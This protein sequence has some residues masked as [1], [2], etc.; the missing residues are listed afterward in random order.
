[1]IINTNRVFRIS[2]SLLLL[3]LI[4]GVIFS[5]MAV[6]NSQ[7][8]D[9][10]SSP[11]KSRYSADSVLYYYPYFSV[12]YKYNNDVI[13]YDICPPA[14]TPIEEL[15]GFMCDFDGGGYSM[16]YRKVKIAV[17]GDKIYLNLLSR[18]CYD[19]A[20]NRIEDI[21][22]WIQGEI[23]G[24]RIRF[25]KQT[26]LKN[27]YI[28][29]YSDDQHGYYKDPEAV[30][31]TITCCGVTYGRRLLVRY[32]FPDLANHVSDSAFWYNTCREIFY[33]AEPVYCDYYPESKLIKDLSAGLLISP[34][35][36]KKIF[37]TPTEREEASIY[38]FMLGR[39]SKKEPSSLPVPEVILHMEEHLSRDLLSIYGRPGCSVRMNIVTDDGYLLD[40]NKM[41]ITYYLKNSE[42]KTVKF[43]DENE[44]SP[45]WSYNPPLNFNPF[46]DSRIQNVASYEFTDPY[47]DDYLKWYIEDYISTL[48]VMCYYEKEDGTR[49]ETPRVKAT[50]VDGSGIEAVKDVS[51]PPTEPSSDGRIYDLTGRIMNPDNLAPGIYI[52]GGKKIIIST[53]R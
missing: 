39:I 25:D 10:I 18:E 36:N 9:C 52:K 1:M 46:E 30:V 49:I 21:P 11:S 6:T 50:I 32:E 2:Y 14:D 5:S 27:S 44:S 26:L 37:S 43:Y 45:Y 29:T 8:Q 13:D 19:E 15:E 42:F 20:G 7:R 48:E 22:V 38:S 47:G 16:H 3:G 12:F 40:F 35:G 31:D 24:N 41:Y 28:R 34:T 51:V 53:N 23:E 4:G 17:S 33:C